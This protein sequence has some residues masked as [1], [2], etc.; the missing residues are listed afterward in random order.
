MRL[1]FARPTAR[2]LGKEKNLGGSSA[3]RLDSSVASA[4]T[5]SGFDSQTTMPPSSGA[6]VQR[7]WL[8]VLLS[9]SFALALC[10]WLYRRTRLAY[11]SPALTTPK[12]HPFSERAWAWVQ[13]L[14]ASSPSSSN[15][16]SSNSAATLS[17]DSSS[18]NQLT[19]GSSLS[20]SSADNDLELLATARVSG[21]PRV[22]VLST[23]HVRPLTHAPPL[24]HILTTS[25]LS[26]YRLCFPQAKEVKLSSCPMRSIAF[27]PGCK[28]AV[29]W[30]CT[31]LRNAKTI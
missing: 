9:S 14:L 28:S 19:E 2:A 27:D 11:A 30:T 31:S 8:W 21:N 20:L 24:F 18:A 3:S 15:P 13:W 29:T 26:C 6:L 10:S 23:R 4:L 22:A 5:S 25:R 7:K 1:K 12:Q 17:P 16:S